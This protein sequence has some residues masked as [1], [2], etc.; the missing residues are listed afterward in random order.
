MSMY[1]VELL[2]LCYV[3]AMAMLRPFTAF[4]DCRRV[5]RPC[6]RRTAARGKVCRWND[7]AGRGLPRPTRIQWTETVRPAQI[8]TTLTRFPRGFTRCGFE[9]ESRTIRARFE[10]DSGRSRRTTGRVLGGTD[11]R[12]GDGDDRID[13]ESRDNR[14]PAAGLLRRVGLWLYCIFHF[15]LL[16]LNSPGPDRPA[17]GSF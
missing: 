9:M 4:S 14:L 7:A 17:P 12:R 13:G 1:G 10:D 5:S 3:Y 8:S 6:L 15:V 11:R 2:C 16:V